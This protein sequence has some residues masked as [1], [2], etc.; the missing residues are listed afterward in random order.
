MPL[1][2]ERVGA[3]L[4][5]TDQ[6]RVE[7]WPELMEEGVAAKAEMTGI[8]GGGGG[9]VETAIESDALADWDVASVRFTVNVLVPVAVGVPVMA[10]VE[11]FRVSPAGSDPVILQV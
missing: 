2:M 9:A 4:A 6:E 7:D 5:D 1:L 11:G 8:V 10:P 3:G